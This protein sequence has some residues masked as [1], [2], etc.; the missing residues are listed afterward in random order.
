MAAGTSKSTPSNSH[1]DMLADVKTI[2]ERSAGVP[3]PNRGTAGR[4][5][6]MTSRMI[7][8]PIQTATQSS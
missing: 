4:T 8:A 3:H 5:P 2:P 7:A 1:R 6:A